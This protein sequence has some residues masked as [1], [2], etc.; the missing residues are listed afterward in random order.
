MKEVKA[1]LPADRVPIFESKVGSVSSLASLVG[2]DSVSAGPGFCQKD[3]DQLQRLRVS[4]RP[5]LCDYGS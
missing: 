1:K 5:T 3:C 2:V 4:R